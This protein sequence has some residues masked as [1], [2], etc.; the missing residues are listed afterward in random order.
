MTSSGPGVTSAGHR[1]PSGTTSLDPIDDRG[2][3]ESRSLLPRHVAAAI[4]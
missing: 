2:R 1:K 3:V 4:P